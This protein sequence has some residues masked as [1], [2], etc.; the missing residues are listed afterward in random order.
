MSDG[1][2][3]TFGYTGGATAPAVETSIRREIRKEYD[4]KVAAMTRQH[5]AELS[6][7]RAEHADALKA[8]Q[9]RCVRKVA[10]V[11]ERLEGE[12]NNFKMLAAL[13]TTKNHRFD[14][15]LATKDAG[16]DQLQSEVARRDARAARFAERAAAL[17]ARNRVVEEALD[18]QRRKINDMQDY[19]TGLEKNRFCPRY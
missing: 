4:D 12:E 3:F 6:R 16:I 14:S 18:A 8:A 17:E 13:Q 1:G 2:T 9:A 19:I 5:N 11:T 7:A 10:A 15:L